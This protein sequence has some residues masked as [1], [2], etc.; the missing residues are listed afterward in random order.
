MLVQCTKKLLDALAIKPSIIA[1]EQPL[2]SWHAHL[3]VM[4]RRKTLILMN[5]KNRYIVVLHGLKAKDMKN[6]GDII[7]SAIRETLLNEQI[8]KEVVEKYLKAAPEIVFA[9]TK[10]KSAV[11]KLNSTCENVSFY[12]EHFSM[13]NIIQ[14]HASNMASTYPIFD[15]KHECTRPNEIM[16]ED[17]EALSGIPIFQC[18]AIKI[19]ATLE[20]EN[21]N[22]WRRLMLP[23]NITFEDFHK[24]LQKAFN[25]HDN[26]MHDFIIF[27]S[28]KPV[29][30]LVQTEEDMAYPVDIPMRMEAGVK[31]S[32]YL[33][34]YKRLLYRYDFGDGWEHTIELEDFIFNYNRN[35]P[36]CLDGEGNAPPED[37]GGEGGYDEFLNTIGDPAH[38]DYREMKE[39]A[40]MQ[41][42]REYDIEII[43]RILKYSL[44]AL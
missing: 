22:I 27:D 21:Y 18:K 41:R 30:D 12:T 20:M 7:I 35:Y 5:D 37:V 38:E 40:M 44:N 31:I 29:I 23:Y 34:K 25:W 16:Y 33:P 4:N 13:Q 26:H 36:V 9:K 14:S 24:V 17:L 28:G 2:F 43:N 6:L 19:K 8:A 1:E 32:E 3:L 42:Y 39:W 15:Q 11:A 10:N